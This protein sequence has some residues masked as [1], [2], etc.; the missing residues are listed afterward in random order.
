MKLV[1]NNTL[2]TALP[3]VPD[4]SVTQPQPKNKRMNL[5]S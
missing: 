2:T 3:H 4:L 5:V 1:Y